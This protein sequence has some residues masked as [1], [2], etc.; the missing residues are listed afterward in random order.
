MKLK[1]KRQFTCNLP[2]D[3]L[4]LLKLEAA[5]RNT[6]QGELVEE[7]LRSTVLKAPRDWHICPKCHQK[8]V[9]WNTAGFCSETTETFLNG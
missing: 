6:T 7:A 8:C 5:L 1:N 4:R 3:L 2:E 9:G